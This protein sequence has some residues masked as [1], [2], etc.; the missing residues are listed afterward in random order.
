MRIYEVGA[1]VSICDI[2]IGLVG[3]GKWE[4][5]GE[6][7]VCFGFILSSPRPAKQA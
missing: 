2:V 7:D 4:V 6:S 3:K 1:G 5:G